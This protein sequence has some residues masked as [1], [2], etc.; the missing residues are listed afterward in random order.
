ME[1]ETGV[2]IDGHKLEP[3]R[4]NTYPSVD[5]E[6]GVG[7]FDQYRVAVGILTLHFFLDEHSVV[8]IDSAAYLDLEIEEDNDDENHAWVTVTNSSSYRDTFTGNCV[9]SNTVTNACNIVNSDIS[10]SSM[11]TARL[12]PLV[13][14]TVISSRLENATI[15]DG[16]FVLNSSI[17][18]STV[19]TEGQARIEG[20]TM[21]NSSFSSKGALV[22]EGSK[23]ND[24]SVHAANFIRII[25]SRLNEMYLKVDDCHIPNR[26]YFFSL[27]FPNL[28]LYCY[29]TGNDEFAITRQ[30]GGFN[31]PVDDP[32]F[33]AKLTELLVDC[34]LALPKDIYHYV[35]D[36]IRSRRRII[37]VLW[38]EFERTLGDPI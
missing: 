35:V 9:L 20:S 6:G 38:A 29:Q 25:D 10:R 19:H 28:T 4:L 16:S 33:E 7:D 15:S 5:D 12:H 31:V 2:Y 13:N 24:A 17:I 3:I 1:H 8:K 27:D 26:L 34:E 11:Q 37:Q 18:N 21:K 22:L 30:G 36:C 23:F 14:Q 32:E